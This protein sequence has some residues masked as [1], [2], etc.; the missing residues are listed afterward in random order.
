VF[1]IFAGFYFW[2]PKFFGVHFSEIL[3]KIHFWIFFTGVNVTFFPMHFLGLAGMPRRIP[4]F[5]DA[6][7]GW[8]AIASFGSFLSAIG[9]IWFFFVVIEALLRKPATH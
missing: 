3:G 8:N 2:F 1:A 5:P 4:D 7:S 6:Y 9:A